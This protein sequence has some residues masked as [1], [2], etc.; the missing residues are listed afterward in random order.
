MSCQF[1][2]SSV[3]YCYYVLLLEGGGNSN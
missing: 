2:K 1:Q 3:L